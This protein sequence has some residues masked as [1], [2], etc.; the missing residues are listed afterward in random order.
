MSSKPPLFASLFDRE[1]RECL[2]KSVGRVASAFIGEIKAL[3]PERYDCFE[4][5][6]VSLEY[7][8]H[9]FDPHGEDRSL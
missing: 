6:L 3:D 5:P 4:M 2:K 1:Q 8:I 9:V 7:V